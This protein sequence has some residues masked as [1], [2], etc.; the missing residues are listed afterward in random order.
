LIELGG[1]GLALGGQAAHFRGD[2]LEAFAERV[3]TRY[4]CVWVISKSGLLRV[5]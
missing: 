4:L 5:A 3:D 2:H 1:S